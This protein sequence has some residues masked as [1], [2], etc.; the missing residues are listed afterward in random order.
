MLCPKCGN[1]MQSRGIRKN[2]HNYWCPKCGHW[3][4]P[5]MDD[6]EDV[7]PWNVNSKY[8]SDGDTIHISYVTDHVPTTEE[9][10]KQYE[11]NLDEWE[12]KSFETTDWQMGRADKQ[13]EIT[14]VQGKAT[15]F[16]KDSGQINRVWLHRINVKFIRK[17]KE[18]RARNVIHELL[19]EAKGFAPKYP[20]IKYPKLSDGMLYEVS[21]PDIHFGRLTWHDESGEDFDVKIAADAV[22]RVVDELLFYGSNYP[23]ARI[24]LPIGNDFFNFDNKFGTT[25]AGTPQQNDTRWQKTFKLGRQLATTMIEKCMQ[26]AP[27]T[28][29]IVKGNHDEQLSFFLGDVLE[30]KFEKNPNVDID[31]SPKGRKYFAFGQN[32]IGFAHGYWEKMSDLSS[33]MPVEV[34]ELWAKSTYREFHT[35]DKH[36]TKVY[37]TDFKLKVDELHGIMVRIIPSITS[38]DGWTVDKGFVGSRR[39]AQSFLYHPTEGLKGQF[40][41]CP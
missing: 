2:H 34:P 13:K 9:V 41:A 22:N 28:C 7:S 25:T 36:H 8:A 12:I 23:I 19:V 4:H 39:A 38:A 21:V 32:L 18:I 27:T 24:L 15:G 5:R 16:T 26:I 33:L 20:K 35:G 17:T 31:N 6:V 30:V 14:Y 37:S 40:T 3:E 1:S 10:A 11:V 29:I